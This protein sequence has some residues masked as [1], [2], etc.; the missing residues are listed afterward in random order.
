MLKW[1]L[2]R[3]TINIVQKIK[4]VNIGRSRTLSYEIMIENL[5][6]HSQEIVYIHVFM[7]R[8]IVDNQSSLILWS[9]WNYSFSF[10]CLKS[11]LHFPDRISTQTIFIVCSSVFHFTNVCKQDSITWTTIILWSEVD[12]KITH[13]IKNP[14][15]DF[16]LSESGHSKQ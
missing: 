14:V 5:S 2:S 7:R 4:Y 10:F 13:C 11:L 3:P 1:T 6:L 12:L 8:K 9:K 15:R 16:Y